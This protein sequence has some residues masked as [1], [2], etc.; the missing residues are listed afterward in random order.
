MQYNLSGNLDKLTRK[1]IID[2]IVQP[3]KT[4][5]VQTSFDYQGPWGVGDRK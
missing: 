3:S 2:Y 5:P 1:E 4:D